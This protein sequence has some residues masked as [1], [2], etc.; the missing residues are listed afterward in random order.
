MNLRFPRGDYRKIV[1]TNIKDELSPNDK[2]IMSVKKNV[3]SKD[4]LFQK[5]LDDGI[6]FN[7]LI[8]RYEIEINNEDT[9]DLEMG[10]PYVFDIVIVYGGTKPR[11][12]FGNLT[13]TKDVTTDEVG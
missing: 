12:T 9:K 2:I 8:N 11:T 5:T 6:K 7:S 13:L 10:T 4:Y 3:H 1:I